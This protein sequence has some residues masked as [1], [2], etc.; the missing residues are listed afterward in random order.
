MNSG[1]II[2]ILYMLAL[3]GIA[4]YAS[5]RDQKNIKDF[6]TGGGLGIFVL[7][8]TFSA[9]YHSAYAFMGAG[10]FVYNHGIGWWVNGLWTVLPGVLFWVWGRRFWFMGKKYNYLSVA[11]YAADVYESNAVGILVTAITMVFTVPYVAM[12]A[13]G[14]TL[15]GFPAGMPIDMA[16]LTAEMARRAPGQSALTTARKEADA[17]EFLSG[18][19]DGV[20]TGQPICILIRNTNQ[21]SRDYGDGVELVRPGHADYTGHVR[22]FGHEDWRGG[23]SFSGR[24]TA[25]IVAAGAL[26]SQWLEAQGVR[27]ACHIQQ[28]GSV[29][30]ASF[31]TA[32]PA[33]D[34]AQLKAMHLPV[35]T[36]G[37]EAAMEA[38]VLAARNDGDSVGGVIE[39]MITGLP[40]GLGAPFFDSVESEIS[41]LLFSVP[42]VKGVEFGEGFGFA[43]LRGSQA[44]D[45]FRMAEGK[46]VTETNH[47]GGINGGITN[48]MP[49]IF[50]CAIRPTPSIARKQQ[51][52]SLKTGE[53]AELEIHGRHDPCI[54]PRAVPVIEAMAAI[55]VLDMWKERQ[56]CLR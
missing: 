50:R 39:C 41:R 55:A 37:L 24:L 13:I 46:V 40:A 44:N 23:G 56:G 43:D 48:G 53:D 28:L 51:T 21:R 12:Q 42:A 29:K 3:L 6:A 45:A 4:F 16:R 2:L 22:Y 27:I 32:D 31:L 33:A 10:G 5:R 54:L 34:Y 25:P 36:P 11:D 19:L 38:E 52:V 7:T 17:P 30:D 8:L 35:L 15:D 47:A 9:T 14:V 26:C 1:I 49:V 20:T 18:V